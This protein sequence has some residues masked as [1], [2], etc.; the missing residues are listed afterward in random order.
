MKIAGRLFLML[1]L[2]ATF[3]TTAHAN[4]CRAHCRDRARACKMRCKLNHPEGASESRHRCLQQC[5]LR[6]AECRERC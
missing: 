5:E 4:R 3:A 6:E 1:T 2:L